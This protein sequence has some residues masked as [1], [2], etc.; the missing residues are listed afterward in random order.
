MK[1]SKGKCRVLDLGKNNH[2]YQYRLGTDLL[3]SSVGERDRGFLVDSRRSMNQP[4]A[5]PQIWWSGASH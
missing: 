1:K 2:R 4:N 3:V 5:E